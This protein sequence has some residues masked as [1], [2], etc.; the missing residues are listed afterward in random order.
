MAYTHTH[1]V[2]KDIVCDHGCLCTTVCVTGAL[3]SGFPPSP[4]GLQKSNSGLQAALQ[5][6]LPNEPAHWL[7]SGF[8]LFCFFLDRVSLWSPGYPGT[9]F[10]DQ[11]DLELRN[12]P[13]SASQVL[14]LKA[15]ANTAQR[16]LVFLNYC[17][18]ALKL[19]RK[20]GFAPL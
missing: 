1:T 19:A 16:F 4:Y 10:V 13:V 5:T 14:G 8:F 18:D 6:P 11:A 9:H 15:C 7:P 17:L 3:G 2:N 12:P 20:S